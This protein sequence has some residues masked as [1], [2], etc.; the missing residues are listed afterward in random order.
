MKTRRAG[1]HVL[2]SGK[3][4]TPEYVLVLNIDGQAT[5]LRGS[6]IEENSRGERPRTP[7]TG[8]GSRYVFQKDIRL[9]AGTHRIFLAVP[10]DRFSVGKDVWLEGGNR[11]ELVLESVYKV[12]KRIGR[13][14]P[15]F[16]SHLSG[17]KLSLNGTAF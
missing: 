5:V 11:N 9:K 14:A 1:F 3:H 2:E 12:G 10:E 16:Y 17:F 13:R 8:V 7:E 15:K 6:L 4:G